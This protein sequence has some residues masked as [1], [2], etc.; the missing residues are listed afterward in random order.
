[1]RALASQP[2]IPVMQS[3]FLAA[4]I[5]RSCQL[6]ADREQILKGCLLRS[7]VLNG[8]SQPVPS[9][10][11]YLASTRAAML[12]KNR[13]LCAEIASGYDWSEG[14]VAPSTLGDTPSLGDLLIAWLHFVE[15]VQVSMNYTMTIEGTRARLMGRRILKA[16]Q[17]PG[18][19]D[20]WD[21]VAWSEMLKV[22]LGS[23]WNNALVEVSVFD[24]RAIPPLLVP[25]QQVLRSDGW[26]LSMSFP[27]S[28]LMQQS[29][30]ERKKHS[31]NDESIQHALNLGKL[32]T[33]I[34]YSGWPGL[35]GFAHFIGVHPK[36]L[37]RELAK[38]GLTGA[39]LVDNA[40][41]RQAK[42][43]LTE[44]RRSITEI[45]KDLGYK[46]PSAFTR[47]V[48]VGSGVRLTSSDSV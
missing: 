16:S 5:D 36:A 42:Q 22:R 47:R 3:K 40:K 19:A 21:I 12:S 24:P 44:G 10:S 32:F 25:Q 34:D 2:V 1:M 11:V 28:W 38:Q 14:F 27:A 9:A 45:G 13:F 17:P 29:K 6:G 43:G 48:V 26:G 20:A 46:N 8:P 31:E 23:I 33:V 39:E 18:Q 15:T 7:D 37:Q 4:V 35:D 41:R 30:F